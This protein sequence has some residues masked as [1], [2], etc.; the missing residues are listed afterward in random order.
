MTILY[1]FINRKDI[2]FATEKMESMQKNH[3]LEKIIKKRIFESL[4]CENYK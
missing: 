2:N 3:A 4:K 1:Y